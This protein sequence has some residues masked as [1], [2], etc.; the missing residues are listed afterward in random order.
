MSYCSDCET[1]VQHPADHKDGC[2]TMKHPDD[3][4]AAARVSD[5]QLREAIREDHPMT[6]CPNTCD[7]MVAFREGFYLS[8]A[9]LLESATETPALDA[10]RLNH[11]FPMDA[12]G[13]PA[14]WQDWHAYSTKH[15]VYCSSCGAYAYPD[16]YGN[17]PE[18]C[19][20]CLAD[21]T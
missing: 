10:L 3:L 18:E 1:E 16:Q 14:D 11:D 5:S 17:E 12:Q 19:G 7:I 4:P 21:L 6:G 15:A 13:Y 9:H 20:N 2:P 8:A